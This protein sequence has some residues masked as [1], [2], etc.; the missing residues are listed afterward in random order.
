MKNNYEVPDVSE[1]GRAHRYIEGTKAIC[2]VCFE[3]LLGA[4]W[5]WLINDID[6]SDE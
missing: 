3:E 4:G 2:P 6:E 1:L 5:T